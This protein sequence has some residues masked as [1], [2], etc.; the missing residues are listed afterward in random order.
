MSLPDSPNRRVLAQVEAKMVKPPPERPFEGQITIHSE[1]SPM[2]SSEYEQGRWVYLFHPMGQLNLMPLCN[3]S[4]SEEE[5]TITRMLD[6]IIRRSDVVDKESLCIQSGQRVGHNNQYHVPHRTETVVGVGF[7]AHDSLPG[8]FW[9]HAG[10][11]MLGGDRCTE[12]FPTTRG[13]GRW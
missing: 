5:V 11:C 8:G 10:L 2:A 12:A 4:P 6:K 13:G 7:A 1:I 9:K 3:D